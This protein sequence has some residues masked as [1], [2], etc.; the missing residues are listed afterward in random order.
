MVRVGGTLVLKCCAKCIPSPPDYQWHFNGVPMRN[1]RNPVLRIDD[2][3]TYVA[4]SY[5]CKVTNKHIN[6]PNHNFVWTRPAK[7]NV[8]TIK[9]SI[10]GKFH[11]LY[12]YTY[13]H[14]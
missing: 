1:M 7:V 11:F 13:M 2:V 4:G 6:D 9:L 12:L 14:V 10:P 3:H 5:A 8:E